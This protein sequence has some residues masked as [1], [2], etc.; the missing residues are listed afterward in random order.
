MVGNGRFLGMGRAHGAQVVGRLQAGE[1]GVLVQ[2]VQLLA[3]GLGHVQVQAL[4]LI[5]P[6]L[7]AAAGLDQPVGID[8]EGVLVDRLDGWLRDF[9]QW[10][11]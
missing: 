5:Q 3:T 2:G 4:G 6:L 8:L 1:P 7:T 10:K 11:I 9:L